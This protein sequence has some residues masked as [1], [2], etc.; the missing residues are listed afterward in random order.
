MA[1]K[2][3]IIISIDDLK[4]MERIDSFGAMGLEHKEVLNSDG[5]VTHT[6]SFTSA[7]PVNKLRTY[8]R[9]IK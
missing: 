9:H 8:K 3:E 5:T 6:L 1:F 7:Q 4:E 2:P